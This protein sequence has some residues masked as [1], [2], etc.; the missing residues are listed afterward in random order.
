MFTAI[1]D[2]FSRVL[3]GAAADLP[4]LRDHRNVA[5]SVSMGVA[6]LSSYMENL[7]STYGTV[8]AYAV[9]QA[10][11]QVHSIRNP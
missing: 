5:I 1:V 11:A 10:C 8:L 7:Y 3:W 6:G 2:G 4:G 9:I